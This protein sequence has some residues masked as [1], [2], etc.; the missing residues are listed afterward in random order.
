MERRRRKLVSFRILPVSRMW[1]LRFGLGVGNIEFGV[2]FVLPSLP[3]AVDKEDFGGTGSVR[4]GDWEVG[5]PVGVD[6]LRCSLASGAENGREIDDFFLRLVVGGKDGDE[7]VV[8]LVLPCC[9]D[10]VIG[11]EGNA[12]PGGERICAKVFALN[13]H[14]FRLQRI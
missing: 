6:G 8:L 2:L 3:S 12:C 5:L 7:G 11:G 1:R 13:G 14:C 4:G 9:G 10:E